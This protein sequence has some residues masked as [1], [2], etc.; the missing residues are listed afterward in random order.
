MTSSLRARRITLNGTQRTT[1]KA[2]ANLSWATSFEDYGRA[3]QRLDTQSGYSVGSLDRTQYHSPPWTP[4][5]TRQGHDDYHVA[6]IIQLDEMRAP[7]DMAVEELNNDDQTHPTER[8]SFSL[9][10][11]GERRLGHA[12]AWQPRCDLATDGHISLRRRR[13][14]YQHNRPTHLS[15]SLHRTAEPLPSIDQKSQTL[16]NI[17]FAQVALQSSHTS[18]WISQR[19]QSRTRSRTDHYEP[20]RSEAPIDRGRGGSAVGPME[21]IHPNQAILD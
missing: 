14:S 10:L 16:S 8:W 4:T 3:P 6:S 15:S 17:L 7:T 21:I 13:G 18:G 1:L 12:G 9:I 5:P 20:P 19:L 2:A 11:Q